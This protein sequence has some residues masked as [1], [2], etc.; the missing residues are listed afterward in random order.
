MWLWFKLHSKRQLLLVLG[1]ELNCSRLSSKPGTRVSKLVLL[2]CNCRTFVRPSGKTW[3]TVNFPAVSLDK[4]GFCVQQPLLPSVPISSTSSSSYITPPPPIMP[5]E[6][7]GEVVQV[8]LENCVSKLIPL[9]HPCWRKSK[10]DQTKDTVSAFQWSLMYI[11]FSDRNGPFRV[12][13]WP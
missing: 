1:S 10:K 2:N 12:T 6:V 13:I 5:F 7:Q 4:D 11:F 9:I 8:C 3:T